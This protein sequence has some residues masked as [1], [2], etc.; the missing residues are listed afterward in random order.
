M[1]GKIPVLFLER[2]KAQLPF[3]VPGQ[4]HFLTSLFCDDVPVLCP[5][6]KLYRNAIIGLI[7]SSCQV[8]GIEPGLKVIP[9]VGLVRILVFLAAD[10]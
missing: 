9:D 7:K 10:L 8:V 5:V 1:S 2:V 4:C 6:R 3:F